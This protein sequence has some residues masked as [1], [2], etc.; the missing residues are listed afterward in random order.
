MEGKYIYGIITGSD[1]TTLDIPGLAASFLRTL[2]ASAVM[3]AVLFAAQKAYPVNL[4]TSRLA[5]KAL[6]I[7]VLFLLAAGSYVGLAAGLRIRELKLVV[8]ILGR[9]RRVEREGH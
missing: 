7:A 6:Y 8:G 2:G 9:K 5:P 1:E 3:G 4:E